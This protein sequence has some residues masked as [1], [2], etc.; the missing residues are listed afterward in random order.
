MIDRRSA[1]GRPSVCAQRGPA[2]I[3]MHDG[4][5]ARDGAREPRTRIPEIWTEYIAKPDHV[6]IKGASG[7]K[8]TGLDCDMEQAVDHHDTGSLRT[9]A[10]ARVAMTV[11]ISA[12]YSAPAWMS[13]LSPS[14]GI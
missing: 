7:R 10:T 3:N 14:E 2:R 6:A 11:T 9:L 8:V 5:A 13:A 1:R 4:L 12:R